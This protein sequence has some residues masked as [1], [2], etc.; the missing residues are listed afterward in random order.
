MTREDKTESFLNSSIK[1]IIFDKDKAKSSQVLSELVFS[2]DLLDPIVFLHEY[3][4]SYLD[5]LFI[6][7]TIPCNPRIFENSINRRLNDRI[8]HLA[9]KIVSCNLTVKH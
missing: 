8:I 1:T 5:A 2:L 7:G 3:M 9:L 4:I 6:I